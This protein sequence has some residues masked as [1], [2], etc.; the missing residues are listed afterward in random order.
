MPKSSAPTWVQVVA[1][2]D[3]HLRE[4]AALRKEVTALRQ[5]V[6]DLAADRDTWRSRREGNW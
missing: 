2:L 6:A 1:E 5:R 4:V 3:D